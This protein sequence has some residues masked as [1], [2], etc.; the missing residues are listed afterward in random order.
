M[1]AFSSTFRGW[2]ILG[3]SLSTPSRKFQSLQSTE[4]PPTPSQCATRE[5]K[6]KRRDTTRTPV[7]LRFTLEFQV[8]ALNLTTTKSRN[9]NSTHSL[10]PSS[11]SVRTNL[12]DVSIVSRR[13]FATAS[14]C[15]SNSRLIEDPCASLLNHTTSSAK[16]RLLL[17]LRC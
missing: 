17:V 16:Q 11:L 9:E 5:T 14:P 3:R 13:E 8:A 4:V 10:L 6:C 2:T 15:P 7:C 12:V 1:I